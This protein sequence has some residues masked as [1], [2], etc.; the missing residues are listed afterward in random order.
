MD[1]S[2]SKQ[3]SKLSDSKYNQFLIDLNNGNYIEKKLNHFFKSEFEEIFSEILLLSKQ[4]F[5]TQI[6][7]GVSL[8]LEDIYSDKCLN[9]EKVINMIENCLQSIQK[10]YIHIF[11]FLSK[12][13]SYHEKISK[14]R[15][16]LNS[17]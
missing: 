9:N 15:E 14:R 13:W 16:N 11:N 8:S 7:N 4:Q 1:N 3:I 2:N 17:E 12:T 6:K 10:D 5:I